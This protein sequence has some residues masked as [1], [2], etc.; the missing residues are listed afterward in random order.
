MLKRSHLFV[1]CQ[2][3]EN[4]NIR[5]ARRQDI[6]VVKKG[7]KIKLRRKK[8]SFVGFR[9]M[10]FRLR[11]HL[12]R[13]REK[14]LEWFDCCG[15]WEMLGGVA[16]WHYFGSKK[17]FFFSFWGETKS[18]WFWQFEND[19]MTDTENW[20]TDWQDQFLVWDHVTGLDFT[21]FHLTPLEFNIN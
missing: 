20:L 21:F 10:D 13:G 16:I 3:S 7:W 17:N 12:E 8:Q 14:D 18:F 19:G 6:T 15:I 1:D 11:F 2:V 5:E 9:H 4:L